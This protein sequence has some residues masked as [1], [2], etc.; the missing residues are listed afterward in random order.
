LCPALSGGGLNLLVAGLWRVVPC[1][2]EQF[3]CLTPTAGGQMSGYG[4]YARVR[5]QLRG[6]RRQPMLVF[7]TADGMQPA[8][9]IVLFHGALRSGSA[10]QVAPHGLTLAARGDHAVPS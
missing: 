10:D 4:G 2:P 5:D 7:A 9:G 6:R 3:D 8:A 1:A